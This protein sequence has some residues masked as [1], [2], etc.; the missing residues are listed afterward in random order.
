MPPSDNDT[1]YAEP[2]SVVEDLDPEPASTR[3]GRARELVL[4]LVLLLTVTA[5][6]LGTSWQEEN[7]RSHYEQAQQAVIDHRWE[8]ALANYSAAKGYKDADTRAAN[9]ARQI[10]ERDLNYEVVSLHRQSGPAALVLKAAR[11]V[12]TIQPGYK[13]ID[14]VAAQAEDNVYT[15]ALGGSVILRP[16]AHTPGLYYRGPTG[17]Q[18]L[19]SSDKWSNVLSIPLNS[20]GV[21]HLVYDVPGPDWTAPVPTPTFNPSPYIYRIIE[22]S[23]DKAGR[24]LI[25]ATLPDGS[26]ELKFDNLQLDPVDFNFYV[27]GDDGVW[28]LRYDPSTAEPIIIKGFFN[29]V[30]LAYD[31]PGQQATGKGTQV[32]MPG[33]DGRVADFGHSGDTLLIAAHGRGGTDMTDSQLYFARGDGS[34]ARLVFSTT[35]DLLSAVLSPDGR[36]ALVVSAQ[37]IVLSSFTYSGQVIVSAILVTLDGSAPPS[38]LQKVSIHSAGT[39]SLDTIRS[40]LRDRISISGVFLENGAFEN[41]LLLAWSDFD[42]SSNARVWLLDPSNPHVLLADTSVDYA[43]TGVIPVIEQPD[44]RTLLMY[45]LGAASPPATGRTTV[46][47]LVTLQADAGTHYVTINTYKVPLPRADPGSEGA[48]YFMNPTLRGTNLIYRVDTHFDMRETYDYNVYSLPLAP[49]L[50]DGKYSN[51]TQPQKIFGGTWSAM[52]A[53]SRARPQLEFAGPGAYA[54]TDGDGTLHAHLYDSDVDVTLERDSGN[55]IAFNANDYFKVLR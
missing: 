51:A 43:Q 55:Q 23:P 15:D 3:S 46:A 49:A 4:G 28:G 42:T 12:Q 32:V 41:K 10:E 54:Y 19:R 18:Y 33:T 45:N 11:A 34:E 24:R 30:S 9:S 22:G 31:K 35:D 38:L 25:M 48:A 2:Q 52:R 50:E 14:A 44:G 39:P 17:W 36:Y 13:D 5:W 20:A 7:N 16:Q 40:M 21:K 26:G 53:M 8:D 6:A 27:C 1:K 29:N 37:P 47:G